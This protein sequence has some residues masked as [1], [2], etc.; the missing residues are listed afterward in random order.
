MVGGGECKN[1]FEIFSIFF[2]LLG[3]LPGAARF[4]QRYGRFLPV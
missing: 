3:L 2:R 1:F 4:L